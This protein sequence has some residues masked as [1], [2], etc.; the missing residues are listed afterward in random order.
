MD[1]TKVTITF[2]L[3][4]FSADDYDF[5]WWEDFQNGKLTQLREIIED[6]ATVE[7]LPAGMTLTTYLRSLKSRE[8]VDL[9]SQLMAVIGEKQNPIGRNGKNSNG[10]SPNTSI[11]KRGSRRKSTLSTNS[12]KCTSVPPSSY[13]KT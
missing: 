1:D 11:T 9:A 4:E 8:V 12:G 5:G 6:Y 3:E 10:G 13:V 2:E 7:G